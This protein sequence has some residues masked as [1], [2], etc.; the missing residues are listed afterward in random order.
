[1][2][3]PWALPTPQS[4]KGEDQTLLRPKR[5]TRDL[6][7]LGDDAPATGAARRGRGFG[8]VHERTRIAGL[9]PEILTFALAVHVAASAREML[10]AEAPHHPLRLRQ[11]HI[12]A[13]HETDG[14]HS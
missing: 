9:D 8:P 6:E 12:K 1:M 11:G 5:R 2:G 14:T 4:D 7:A 3:R 13:Y 10:R